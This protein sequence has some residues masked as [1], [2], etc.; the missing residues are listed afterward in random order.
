MF[1]KEIEEKTH[2]A[3]PITIGNRKVSHIS[4]IIG[5][6]HVKIKNSDLWICEC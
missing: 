1:F 4:N 2:F 6:K 5:Y 3:K